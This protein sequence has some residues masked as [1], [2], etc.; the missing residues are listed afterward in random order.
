M[1]GTGIVLELEV[2]DLDS[3]ESFVKEFKAL[4]LPLHALINNV[5]V[6]MRGHGVQQFSKQGHELHFAVNH[7]AHFHLTSLLED[8]LLSSGTKTNPGR[9]IYITTLGLE[10][11]RGADDDGH[12]SRQIPA[13]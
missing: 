12:L 4:N 3:V 5:A 9:A 10:F 11:R 8:K 7:L 6:M 2:S 13:F 1:T